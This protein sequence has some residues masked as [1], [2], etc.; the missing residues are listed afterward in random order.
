MRL[1]QAELVLVAVIIGYI[2][3][4]THPPPSHITNLLETPIGHVVVLLGILYVTVYQSL[5]VG[6]FLGIAYLMTSPRVTEYMDEKQQT[7]KGPET[8][9]QPKSA[10]VPPPAV[11][12]VLGSSMK[13]KGDTRLPQAQGKSVTAKPTEV[14]PP[15][16]AAPPPTAKSGVENFASF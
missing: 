12:G 16:P 14:V 7:P 2:A 11:T 8:P 5:I 10:G 1:S 6:V 4:F 13:K 9:S 3:F 15:K